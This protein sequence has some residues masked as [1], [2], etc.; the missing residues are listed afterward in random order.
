MPER[1]KYRIITEEPGIDKGQ[2][3]SSDTSNTMLSTVT[4]TSSPSGDRIFAVQHDPDVGEQVRVRSRTWVVTDVHA[5]AL[6]D[7]PHRLVDL[8]SVEDDA[9]GDTLQVIWDLEPGASVSGTSTL[10][11]VAAFDPPERL[12]AFLDAVRWGSIASADVKRLQAPYRSG[13]KIEDYQLAPV[14]RALTMP[15]VNLLIADDVGLGKTIEAGLVILELTLRN[16]ARNIL[17]V[18]PP[19]LQIQWRDQMM[20]KFGLEFRIVNRDLLAQLRRTRGIH[21]NTWDHFPRL[22]TSIDYLKRDRPMRLMRDTLPGPNG[23][24]YPRRFDLLVV[25]EPHNI[26]PSGSAQYSHASDRTQSPR[27]IRRLSS[28][29]SSWSACARCGRSSASIVGAA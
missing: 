5:N 21:A 16:R 15:R 29:S 7:R 2:A 13:T 26:A 9:Q 27:A 14:N 10:P 12:D 3:S 24:R 25:D 6:D 17:V 1:H 20:E 11:E 22:I 8:L 28:R 4:L 19:S 23:P 18:C